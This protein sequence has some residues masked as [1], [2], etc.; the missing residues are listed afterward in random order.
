M[1]ILRIFRDDGV[2]LEW[3]MYFILKVFHLLTKGAILAANERQQAIDLF[4]NRNTV[5]K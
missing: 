1:F 4:K 3:K 5:K 2:T